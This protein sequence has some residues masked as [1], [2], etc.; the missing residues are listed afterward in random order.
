MERDARL[1]AEER[2]TDGWLTSLE[3]RW[4]TRWL[5]RLAPVALA[6]VP[7][8]MLHL[9]VQ[10]TNIM[11]GADT[12]NYGAL[13]DWGCA[14]WGDPA[15]DFHGLPLQAVPFMLEGHRSIAPLDGDEGAEARILWRHVQLALAMLPRGA[16]PGLAWGER[17]LAWLIEVFR[18]F[19]E[20][21]SHPWRD[22]GPVQ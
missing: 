19:T 17:P 9:D 2:A 22:L 8:R 5:D 3:V 21:P 4:L 15:F 14:G 10:A 6:S 11:V 20:A 13:L 7:Q 18:F 1:L 12:M 16:A